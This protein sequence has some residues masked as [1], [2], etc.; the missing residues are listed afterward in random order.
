VTH[1]VS[2]PYIATG[3]IIVLYILIFIFFKTKWEDKRFTRVLVPSRV[4]KRSCRSVN[5]NPEESRWMTSRLVKD[6]LWA[7]Y[8]RNLNSCFRLPVSRQEGAISRNSDT[9]S[10]LLSF[11]KFCIRVLGGTYMKE[12]MFNYWLVQKPILP[13]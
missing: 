5:R 10:T 12:A 3:K 11:I 9:A 1:Q 7:S 6:Q 2:H 8:K 13:T 4:R